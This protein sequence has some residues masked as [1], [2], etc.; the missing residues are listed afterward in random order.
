MEE[1]NVGVIV[2]EGQD[3]ETST[4]TT[5]QENTRAG[6]GKHKPGGRKQEFREVGRQAGREVINHTGRYS[7]RPT[8]GLQRM[9]NRHKRVNK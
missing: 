4:G 2:D 6:R 1:G 3:T 8:P 7:S 5:K 9:V